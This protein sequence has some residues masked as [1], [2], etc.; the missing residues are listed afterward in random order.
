MTADEAIQYAAALDRVSPPTPERPYTMP[1]ELE[2]LRAI[3]RNASP[4]LLD[5]TRRQLLDRAEAFRRADAPGHQTWYHSH[6]RAA[7]YICQH[8]AGG[9]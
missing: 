1:G 3:A 9:R 5:R 2:V 8:Y 4:A 6:L 7:A